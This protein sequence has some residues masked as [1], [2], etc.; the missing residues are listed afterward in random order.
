MT[1]R[2]I[3]LILIVAL[4]AALNGCADRFKREL[5][6]EFAQVPDS[7]AK[8]KPLAKGARIPDPALQ[9][10][11]GEAIN[12]SEVI[13]GQ[14]A[15]LIFYRGGWCPYCNAHLGELR[16]IEG[17]LRELGYRVIA[18]SPDKPEWLAQTLDK[19]R[20]GFTLLS[21]SEAQAAV[22]FGLAF[23]VSEQS[24]AFYSLGGVDLA[25]RSGQRHLLLPVP[26]AYVIKADGTV[27]FV[28]ANPDYKTRVDRH[29]LL[30]AAKAAL[31]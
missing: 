5:P 27:A 28:Y 14:P 29:K 3:S 4:I 23:R 15:I 18:I 12:L 13:G 31:R 7:A 19:R 6:P 8:V 9:T 10:I 17:D 22:A 20:I 24:L 30:R 2:L 21:D 25:E 16:L 1:G 11:N 26:A